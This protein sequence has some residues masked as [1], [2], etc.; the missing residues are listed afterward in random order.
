MDDTT[1]TP[2]P[3]AGPS[4]AAVETPAQ[5]T[6]PFDAALDDPI[7][8]RLTARARRAI[9]PDSLPQLTLL[10]EPDPADARADAPDPDDVGE[11]DDVEPL[12]FEDAVAAEPEDPADTRPARAR[13]LRHAGVDV[14]QIADELEVDELVVRAWVDDITPVRSAARRLRSVPAGASSAA[15]QRARVE[16]RRRRAE[17]AFEATR[18]SARHAA[19]DRIAGDPAFVSGL[20]LVAGVADVTPRGIVLTTRDLAVARA[21]VRWLTATVEVDAARVRILL[22]LAPQVA[23]DVTVHAWHAATGLPKERFTTARWRQA[24]TADAVEAMVRI[25]DPRVAG[26]LAGWRDALLGSLDAAGAGDGLEHA[27]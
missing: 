18:S 8:F 2:P 26:A 7:P 14:D 19:A 15:D 21:A 16:A 3:P 23:A 10:D 6:L 5:A 9:A 17:Q 13:A 25:S 4:D 27:W 12:T 1:T 24:P 11:A 22:R 20:G